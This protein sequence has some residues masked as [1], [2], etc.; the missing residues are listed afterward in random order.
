LNADEVAVF[1]Q[2]LAEVFTDIRLDRAQVCYATRDRQQAVRE[3]A[4]KVEYILILG[5]FHSS[6]AARLL[7][8]ARKADVA[9]RQIDTPEE[10]VAGDL[11][12]I[13]KLGLSAGASVPDELV[14]RTVARLAEWGFVLSREG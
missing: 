9:A 13:R 11:A 1:Q 8:T 7:E 10:L 14:D 2:K 12:G 3:L 5:S 4:K 6:N